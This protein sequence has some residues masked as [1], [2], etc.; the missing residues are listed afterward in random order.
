MGDSQNAQIPTE[1][2]LPAEEDD[3]SCE[4]PSQNSYYYDDATGYAI[5]NGESDNEADEQDE[6]GE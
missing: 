2:R 3:A 1:Q 4:R 6:R 5:Y